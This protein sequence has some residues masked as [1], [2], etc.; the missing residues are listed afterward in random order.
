M[1]SCTIKQKKQSEI[2][3]KNQKKRSNMARP[4]FLKLVKG[5][6]TQ[7]YKIVQKLGDGGFGVVK[8]AIHK[9]SN[10]KRAI[11]TIDMR[12]NVDISKMM[13]EVN[14][15]KD[16]DHPNI[17]KVFEVIEDIYSF[18]IVMEYCSG[19]ELFD[20]IKQ[21]NGFSE[22]MAAAY[23]LDIVTAVKYCHNVQIVHRDLKP[24]NI[25]FENKNPDARLKIIDFGTSQHFMPKE[26]MKRF[27]GTSYY[28]AP[29]VIDKNYDQ[30]CD[31]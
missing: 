26:K 29:E 6:I 4:I 15:L 8:L 13:E 10:A 23:M 28:M 24:E 21:T 16:L 17:V 1:G 18:N 7:N 31:V 19:G 22:N 5:S 27:I 3:D 9:Q 25:L 20:K 2:T 12:Q 14:I 11:K 30:K